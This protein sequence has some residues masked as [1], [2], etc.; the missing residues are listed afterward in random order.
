[1]TKTGA[2]RTTDSRTNEAL[3][4]LMKALQAGHSHEALELFL[5]DQACEIFPK[6]HDTLKW[7]ND[8][9]GKKAST[10]LIGAFACLAC[11]NCERGLRECENCD[12][13]GHFDHDMVCESCLGL[14][15]T[16]CDFCGGTGLASIDFIPIGLRLA[17]FAVRL[18]NAE[19]HIADLFKEPITSSSTQD[20]D[21]AFG[22]CVD[23]LFN[24]NRQISVLE[25]A[26]GVSTD[27]IEVPDGL[28]KRVSRI[29][30]KAVRV[31][32]NG[33]KGLAQT[34]ARMVGAC[35]LQARN[36]K[37]GTETGKLARA[38]KKFYSSLLNS[39]P[40]FAGTYLEHI[41]LN[42]AAKRLIANKGSR[43]RTRGRK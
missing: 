39:K 12:G 8:N 19:K 31:A 35:D 5:K 15:S 3:E 22:N 28:S 25:S 43:D 30:H 41:S 17:V 13:A 24:L 4:S 7:L 14:R 27:L 11:F 42:K 6:G 29:K 23:V 37:E 26:V 32:I 20:P 10:R 33:E 38:R 36:A 21:G 34:V 18:E 16:S 40:P 1:V 2:R 9:I